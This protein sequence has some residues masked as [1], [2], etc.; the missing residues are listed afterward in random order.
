MR[1]PFALTLLCAALACAP[2]LASTPA[3]E[4]L[5]AAGP[6][7]LVLEGGRIHTS[8]GISE[9][10]AIDAKGVILALGTRSEIA[11]IAAAGVKRVELAGATVLPGFHDMHVHPVF[12]GMLQ[13]QCKIAQGARLADIQA[14][15]KACVAAAKPGDWITGGQWDA[16]AIGRIPERSMLDAVAPDNPVVL[17]DTSGHSIWAN[18]KA[19]AAAGITKDT[20]APEGGIIERDSRGEPTGALRETANALVMQHVPRPDAAQTRRALEWALQEM[21]SYGIT[22]FTEASLGFSAGLETEAGTWT[23]L[24]DAGV[25]KQRARICMTWAPGSAEAESLI[26]ARNTYARDRLS[27][28]C[29][30]IFLDGVPTDSHTAA[31]LEPYEGKVAGRDDEASRRGLLLVPQATLDEAVTRFDRMGLT[32]KFHAAGDAAV[33]AGLHAVGAARKA[34]G[35]STLLHDVGHCTFVSREDLGIAR[36]VGASF[37]VSPYLWD[38]SPINDD[39]TRAVGEARIARVW[40]VREMIDA[41][42][43]VIPGS[44]WAVVP[45]VNPWIAV[46]TL[47]TRENP[48]G[49]KRAFGKPQ[50]ISL[51]EA[52]QLFTVNSARHEGSED[53]LGS[54]APGMIADLVVIDQ[55]PYEVPAT[56]LH[57]TTVL[58]TIINGEIVWERR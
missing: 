27:L 4:R 52:I 47:V 9:S 12:G 6:A 5:Q 16:S 36:Q 49:S 32:V 11:A 41:G 8:S 18:S 7:A 50:A 34:N 56:R 40:P 23:A 24:A 42:A 55:D 39:I 53:R 30:K 15:I 45:S 22:S 21:L 17:H 10:M 31:M 54:I 29:V 43:H 57:K 48:G 33:R 46:E 19:L 35:F 51:A 58:K 28:D 13:Q 20:V 14:R 3:A 44:D 25:L 38:P 1:P 37:E 2:V 26:A